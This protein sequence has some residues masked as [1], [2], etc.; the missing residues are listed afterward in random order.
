MLIIIIFLNYV[1]MFNLFILLLYFY[2]LETK[3]MVEMEERFSV[4]RNLNKMVY[5]P[6]L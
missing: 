4:V 3:K 1:G 2:H 6:V 5:T